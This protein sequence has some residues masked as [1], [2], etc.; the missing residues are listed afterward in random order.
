MESILTAAALPA[1]NAWLGS[2]ADIVAAS[3]AVISI[4][5]AI[6]SVGQARKANAAATESATSASRSNGIAVGANGLA[7]SANSIARDANGTA[8]AAL[9]LAERA[10]QAESEV[11]AREQARLVYAEEAVMYLAG[12]G[13]DL[14]LLSHFLD[15]SPQFVLKRDGGGPIL[16]RE[17]REEPG[18]D[19]PVEALIARV[20]VVI[21]EV[22]VHNRSA[23]LL[24]DVRVSL[25]TPTADVDVDGL[26]GATGAILPGGRDVVRFVMREGHPQIFLPVLTFQDSLGEWWTRRGFGIVT[27]W[28]GDAPQPVA[29]PEDTATYKT[30]TVR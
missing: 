21:V 8:D 1:D 27:R 5:F 4:I 30:W 2:G 18:V 9:A 3:V 6:I 23:E 25:M 28:E 22:V 17:E 12:P 13:S 29:I 26:S 10:F 14:S 24:P 20:Q 7:S 11:R 15:E 16:G 19:I